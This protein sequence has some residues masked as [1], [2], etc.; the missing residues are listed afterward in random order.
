MA[1]PPEPDRILSRQQLEHY[2][3]ELSKLS[4]FNLEN[5]YEIMREECRF[6]DG[7]VPPASAI[8]SL[9]AIWNEMR[10]WYPRK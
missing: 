5:V 1:H 2:R 4:P 8:Q 10:K 7:K 3:I 9:V 6:R